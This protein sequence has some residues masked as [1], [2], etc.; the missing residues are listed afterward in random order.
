MEDLVKAVSPLW[1]QAASNRGLRGQQEELEE[2]PE[3]SGIGHIA[4]ELMADRPNMYSSGV[5][6][7]E[8]AA[9]VSFQ[10]YG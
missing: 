3:S 4:R 9:L 8:D 1:I 5:R 2:C 10:R 7:A 6:G